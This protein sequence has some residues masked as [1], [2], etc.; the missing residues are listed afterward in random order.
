M[1]KKKAKRTWE[2][3]AGKG[4]NTNRQ[5][6]QGGEKTTISTAKTRSMKEE[7]EDVETRESERKI[8]GI[9]KAGRKAAKGF[10]LIRQIKDDQGVGRSTR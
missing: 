9:A 1:A 5:I 10:T 8:F 3:H 2:S 4:L 6:E 7:Y